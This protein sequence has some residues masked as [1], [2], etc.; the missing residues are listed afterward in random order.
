MTLTRAYRVTYGRF[1][2]RSE[3]RSPESSHVGS[4]AA[5]TWLRR[6]GIAIVISSG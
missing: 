3:P 6:H 5:S 2:S 1:D 4:I